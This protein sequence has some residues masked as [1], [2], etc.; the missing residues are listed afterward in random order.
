MVGLRHSKGSATWLFIVLLAPLSVVAQEPQPRPDVHEHVA[1]SAPLLTPTNESSG[2]SWLPQTTP[3]YGIHQPWRGWD[4]RA[5]GVVV[6]DARYEP[7][8]RHRTGGFATRQFGS[9]NWGMLM[10]RRNAAGGRFGIRSMFSAEPW[11]VSD[12]GSISFLAAG[13][14]CEGDGIHDRQQPHDFVME[15]AVDYDRPLRGSWRWQI[16]AAAAGEPAI[17]V[18]GYPHRASALAN[19][20]GPISHHWLESTSTFGVV[21]LGVHNQRWKAEASVFNGREPD[22]SRV[23]F[24]FGGF[25]SVAARVS[26]LPTERMAI[27]VS[28]ARLRS[29]WTDFPFEIRMPPPDS[30][31]RRFITGRLGWR[32]LGDESALGTNHARERVALGFLDATSAAALVESSATFS[33]R[34]SVFGRVEVGGMP[35]HHLHAHEFSLAGRHH[36]QAA[37]GLRSAHPR[38]EG[39]PAGRRRHLFS[40]S[41]AYR[42]GTALFQAALLRA[43]G[44][45]SAFMLPDTK[46]RDRDRAKATTIIKANF[47]ELHALRN[48]GGGAQE[49]RTVRRGL[50]GGV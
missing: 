19:P 30:L 10:A 46:C 21:T 6:A 34:H 14:V 16:Y 28:G 5:N 12:C 39:N 43:S 50:R 15:L 41:P 24:D 17:G 36:R 18:P 49:R 33:E 8:D 22:D 23:D 2:T 3:M 26:F 47:E 11:T 4:V 31:R 42:V 35:A 20:V 32:H 40:E 9:M 48:A 44:C 25:D 27:Q 38:F 13:E 1:V 45:S 7:G 29:A 37:T